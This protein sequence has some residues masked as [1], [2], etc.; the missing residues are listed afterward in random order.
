[1]TR[2]SDELLS[3]LGQSLLRTAALA[4]AV[5]VLLVAVGIGLLVGTN[6]P[7]P[8]AGGYVFVAV[9]VAAIGG[10]LL[11]VLVIVETALDLVGHVR[12][13]DG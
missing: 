8:R 13:R 12:P 1:M 6:P 3:L 7:S 9:V 5:V 2:R 4:I 11:S 10:V